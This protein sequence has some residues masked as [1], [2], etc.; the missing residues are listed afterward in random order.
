MINRHLRHLKSPSLRGYVGQRQGYQS[1]IAKS[2]NFAIKKGCSCH[3]K[4]VLCSSLKTQRV[5]MVVIYT[6]LKHG[7]NRP[8]RVKLAR[9]FLQNIGSS[10]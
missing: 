2:S 5:L 4:M 9:I 10:L 7:E 3:V 8:I 1:F 6:H